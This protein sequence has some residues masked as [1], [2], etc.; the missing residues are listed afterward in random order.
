ML[1]SGERKYNMSANGTEDSHQFKCPKSLLNQCLSILSDDDILLQSLHALQGENDRQSFL[2]EF[3]FFSKNTYSLFLISDLPSDLIK[4]VAAK[5]SAYC[6]CLAEEQE[7]LAKSEGK[8]FYYQQRYNLTYDYKSYY[9]VS[10]NFLN[11]IQDLCSH[12]GPLIFLHSYCLFSWDCSVVAR[13]SV[14]TYDKRV[15]SLSPVQ[16]KLNTVGEE[17]NAKPSHRN[18]TPLVKNGT[19][20]C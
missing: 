6:L 18:F 10:W 13:L 2:V 16:F 7:I 3:G 1:P 11:F 4:M 12:K 14:Q 19:F 5:M 17:D 9:I 20:I 8:V 15:V